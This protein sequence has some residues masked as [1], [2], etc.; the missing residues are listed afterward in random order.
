[1]PRHR[2]ALGFAPTVGR[3]P[4][5]CLGNS[6]DGLFATHDRLEDILKPGYFNSF[7]LSWSL[8]AG[9]PA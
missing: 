8:S 9:R 1:M 3:K 2:A 4:M 6:S 7:A 5:K